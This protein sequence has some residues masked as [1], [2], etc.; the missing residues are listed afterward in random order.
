MKPPPAM[1]FNSAEEVIRAKIHDPLQIIS[2]IRNNDQLGFLYMTPAVPKS[3]I[4]YDTYNL[5]IVTHEHINKHDYYT[6]SQHGVTH[7]WSGEVDF[8]D[9]DRWEQEY[10][11]HKRLLQIPAFSLFRKWKAF[12]VWRTNV[13]SK[14]INE[15][16][17][18]LQDHLFIVNDTTVEQDNEETC[19]PMYLSE[20]MLETQALSFLPS[21]DDFKDCITEIIQKFQETVLSLAN[22][23]PDSYFD[24]FTQPTINNK[25]E[26][27]TCGDGPSLASMFEDDKHLHSIVQEIKEALQFAFDAANVYAGTFE[28]FRL[29]YKEN[30]GLDLEALRQQDHGAAFF[31][32]QLKT[33]H[34]EH[35]DA[36]AIKQKRNLGMLL[37]DTT[38]L[39]NKLI[40]SPLR[41]LEVSNT[42]FV[43]S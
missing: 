35:K 18:A 17:K 10:L 15:C 23:V 26:E 25:T 32:E 36:L 5:K 1:K 13:R 33:Y 40:P 38:Q 21:A 4:Q 28:R 8:L 37:I 43:F 12:K 2:I 7:T 34:T 24:A 42:L 30:E 29:F 31:G 27:K 39:K 14:K 16:R 11:Y 6:I 19:I 41:C 20:L 22:L 9:L 3:S